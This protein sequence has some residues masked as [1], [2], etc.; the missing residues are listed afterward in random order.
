MTRSD[1]LLYFPSRSAWCYSNFVFYLVLQILRVNR[2]ILLQGGSF[3]NITQTL[4][5]SI[6]ILIKCQGFQL[7]VMHLKIMHLLMV[8]YSL[9]NILI[10]KRIYQIEILQLSFLLRTCLFSYIILPYEFLMQLQ[11]CKGMVL[12]IIFK[13]KKKIY[14]FNSKSYIERT[15]NLA[16]DAYII[17]PHELQHII[18]IS[19]EAASSLQNEAFEWCFFRNHPVYSHFVDTTTPEVKNTFLNKQKML[20]FSLQIFFQLHSPNF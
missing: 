8:N 13:I 14:F 12:Y 3:F 19:I 20:K 10:Q 15:K 2:F 16:I 18:P 1:H 7:T 6:I 4:S 11:I 5:Y 9:L 17:I